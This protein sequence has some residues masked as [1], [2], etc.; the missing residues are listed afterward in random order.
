MRRRSVLLAIAVLAAG[1]LVASLAGAA[2]G[3]K[4]LKADEL[5]GYQEN[6]DVSTAATGS[7]TVTIDDD[8]QTITYELSYSGIEGGTAS[9]AHIHFGK[10]A[11]NGGVSAFLCSGG[12]KPACPATAG[13]VSG[14]IDAADIIGPAGQGIEAGE[15]R[16][17]RGR[18]AQR[19][20]VRQRPQH[21]RE[22]GL[23]GRRDPRADQRPR[24]QQLALRT[25]RQSRARLRPGSRLFGRASSRPMTSS[26]KTLARAPSTTRWSNV[27]ASQPISRTT[28]SP[29]TTAGRGADP[30][31]A[32]DADLGVVDERRG[33]E[34]AE[35]AGARHRE[36]RAPQLLGPERPGAGAL[37]EPPR[38]GLELVQR[39]RVGGAEHGH[40]QALVGLHRQAEV[41]ALPEDDLLAVER[42]VQLR[43]LA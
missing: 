30:V 8:A 1:L 29:S 33:E 6:P 43:D 24:E 19:Q 27:Q 11:V 37:G 34:A 26:R 7:F 39:L 36:R 32:E 21:G 42:R 10:R 17:A 4:N 20:H 2:G 15:L 41:V 14:V 18:D 23:A 5:T 9:A 38:L 40:D 13:T 3:K 12:D 25:V 16:R 35:L 31:Q 28:T 22:P